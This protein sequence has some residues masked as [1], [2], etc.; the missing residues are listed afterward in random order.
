MIAFLLL[1]SVEGPGAC[2][3]SLP[4]NRKE[5][6]TKRQRTENVRR[7]EPASNPQPTSLTARDNDRPSRTVSDNHDRARSGK[8][9][10]AVQEAACKRRRLMTFFLKGFTTSRT[11]LAIARPP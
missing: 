8:T 5:E 7:N 6:K 9:V 2:A 10:S 4:F 11:L 1:L 3:V